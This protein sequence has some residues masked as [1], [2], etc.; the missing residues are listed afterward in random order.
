MVIGKKTTPKTYQKKTIKIHIHTVHSL[1]VLDK[2]YELN[3][4]IILEGHCIVVCSVTLPMNATTTKQVRLEM[5][6]KVNN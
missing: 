6:L 1:S 4:L 3:I 2:L 5:P